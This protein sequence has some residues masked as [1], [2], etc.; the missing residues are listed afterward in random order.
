[1]TGAFLI[2][3]LIT[4]VAAMIALVVSL[5]ALDS[6]F[7]LNR[8]YLR[9]KY[10]DEFIS[11]SQDIEDLEKVLGAKNWEEVVKQ[12]QFLLDEIKKTVDPNG[13]YNDTLLA[14]VKALD[15][16]LWVP[17]NDIALSPA[18]INKRIIEE[19]L[20][21]LAKVG[22]SA[23]EG[24]VG[25]GVVGGVGN[26]FL[27]SIFVKA[28]LFTTI[29]ASLGLAGGIVLGPAAY[30]AAVI[31]AP[32]SMAVVA[33]TGVFWG[34]NTLRNKGEQKKLS[35][36]LADI[37][38]AAL[39]MAWIDGVLSSEEE[40]TIKQIMQNSAIDDQDELRVNTA[41]NTHQ[42]FDQILQD[43]LLKEGNPNKQQMKRRLVL[44]TAYE[45][46]K[47][48]GSISAEELALHDRMAKIMG[49]QEP[50][51]KEMRRLLLLKSGV[52]IHD[53]IVVIQGDITQESTDAVVSSTNPNLRPGKKLG[54]INL[55]GNRNQVDTLIHKIAGQ[56][57]I[58]QCQQL[59]NCEVGGVVLTKGYNLPAKFLIHTVVP[60]WSDG[61]VKAKNLL[62]QCYRNSLDL[63][64]DNT[65]ETIAFPA[66]GT[67]TG[68]F[69]I[70]QAAAIAIATAREFLDTHFTVKQIRFVC[71]DDQIYQQFVKELE[72]QIG[73]LPESEAFDVSALNQTSHHTY[74]LTPSSKAE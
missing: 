21:P 40:D 62:N 50:E 36:F 11:I 54:L 18:E 59:D 72:N 13:V 19:G 61:E 34:A 39:P 15:E 30:T 16:Y 6:I 43:G 23:L 52:N 56:E 35:R 26:A 38:I 69:P 33:G 7:A 5:V 31:A 51:I 53:R 58:N 29:K 12:T 28:S 22:G 63:A 44:F 27:S 3:P 9:Q 1:M 4:P 2:G 70:N 41:M 32:I 64:F 49:I 55:P 37:L 68:K 20:P 46:A 24:V 8:D 60:N 48:D 10:P 47:S 66:L 25:G 17:E 67:G 14:A 42:S 45:L 73:I 65:F 71:N 57:L 74:K